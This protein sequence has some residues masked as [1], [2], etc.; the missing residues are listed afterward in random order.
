MT[1]LTTAS[2]FN[3]IIALVLFNFQNSFVAG[4]T[5]FHKR[6]EV[7]GH[8]PSTHDEIISR[9]EESHDLF[10]SRLVDVN[11]KLN[12]HSSGETLLNEAEFNRLSRKKKAFE[13]KL[14]EL[15]REFDERHS[16]RTIDR[17]ELLN[18]M[19]RDRI[20][21]SRGEL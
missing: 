6:D 10:S 15:S 4:D 19:T 7:T 17:E 18:D 16:R 5:R 11:T 3:A 8:I 13:N 1:R 21:R 9:R 12:H 20:G 2:A 14:K